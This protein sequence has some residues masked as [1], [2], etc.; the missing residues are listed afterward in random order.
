[1]TVPDDALRIVGFMKRSPGGVSIDSVKATVGEKLVDGRKVAAYVAWGFIE[2]AG[3]EL[4]LTEF[5]RAL[6]RADA[7]E[8]SKFFARVILGC[9]PYRL[10]VDRAHYQSIEEITA[11]DMAA[12][13]MAHAA[14]HVGRGTGESVRRQAV[15]FFGLAQAA[16]LGTMFLGRRGKETRLT[17]DLAAIAALVEQTADDSGNSRAESTTAAAGAVAGRQVAG[18]HAAASAAA[19][20]GGADTDESGPAQA[21]GPLATPPS[22]LAETSEGSVFISHGK[23]T[24]VLD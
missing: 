21:E 20:D 8:H 23:N 16:G 19:A 4:Q 9:D 18:D 12:H 2:K 17:F 6:A 15:C 3:D 5:G 22:S 7:E 14:D 1:M 11:A 10:A 13:W 24:R